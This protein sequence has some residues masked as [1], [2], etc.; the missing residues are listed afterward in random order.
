[1]SLARGQRAQA[2]V[3][4]VFV[5]AAVGAF[6]LA[7]PGA[8]ERT[9][10]FNAGGDG[11]TEL[12]L[13]A[14][15]MSED[16]PV[17]GVGIANFPIESQNVRE[18][19]NLNFVR[20]IVDEPLVAH[21]IYLQQLAETGLIGLA[22]LMCVIVACLASALRA[23]RRFD[24]LG[25]GP[26]ATLARAT[27]V[28]MVGFLVASRFISDSTDRRLWIVLALGPA[29]LGLARRQAASSRTST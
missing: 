5:I 20:L 22:L 28:A 18:P 14:S 17:A 15:R 11:R 26:V 2:A 19:G 25:D 7:T 9:T 13:V 10:S 3:V 1:M 12:W 27:A 8:L 4:G 23:A 6:L 21:N 24:A 29:L 16:H